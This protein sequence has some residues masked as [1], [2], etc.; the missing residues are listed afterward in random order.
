M[1]DRPKFAE[2]LGASSRHQPVV[3]V[4]SDQET[5][6]VPDA[7]VLQRKNTSLLALL[8]SHARGTTSE[9][10]VNPRPSIP[11]P[12]RASPAQPLEKKRKRDK[13]A[14]KEISKKGKI[15]PSKDHEPLKGAKIAK[16]QQ[17]RS[18][19]EGYNGEVAPDRCLKVPA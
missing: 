6:N 11:L 19:V 14:R 10:A 4:S 8:E 3:S 15:Q 13:K 5:T 2:S 7:M 17:R 1:F 9:V 16:G 18:S 12:S